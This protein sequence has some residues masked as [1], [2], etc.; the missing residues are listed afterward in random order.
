MQSPGE[1]QGNARRYVILS[2]YSGEESHE[3]ISEILREYAKDD[4]TWIS[5]KPC[6]DGKKALV[7]RGVRPEY[8][9]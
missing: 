6:M 8:K 5:A 2:R 3:M 4:I 9:R 7:I 1:M